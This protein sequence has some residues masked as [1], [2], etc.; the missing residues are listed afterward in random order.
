MTQ[1]SKALGV[2][3]I[4]A[5]LAQLA[6]ACGNGT[7]TPGDSSGSCGSTDIETHPIDA[8]QLAMLEQTLDCTTLCENLGSWG[9][10]ECSWTS[11]PGSGSATDDPTGGGASSGGPIPGS[12]SLADGSGTS[13][14]SGTDGSGTTS[15]MGTTDGSTS[16]HGSTTWDG[17]GTT[18]G[19]GGPGEPVATLSCSVYYECVGGRGHAA[20][21][22]AARASTAD[23][24]GEWLA[25]MAH[26][27][28]ASVVAFR[29]IAD[30]LHAHGAP[31][32]LVQR[33]R[34]AADD[35]VRHA[36]VMGTLARRRGV[37]P[38]PPRFSAIE[39]RE[40]EALARENAV[41]GCVRETWAALEACCQARRATDPALRRA[42]EGIGADESRHAQLSW[43]LDAWAR[44]KLSPA[45]IARVDAARRAAVEELERGL[46]GS[47]PA[48]LHARAGIP[49][50]AEARALLAELRR[51]LWS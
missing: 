17:F 33:A 27:E 34:E 11:P 8:A 29:A 5:L 9:T 45:A 30:E 42:M 37:E 35:E 51:A 25:A 18:T 43:D 19:D 31:A 28:A 48:P 3:A 24:L 4:A 1:T 12:T 44:T 50:P 7:I 22:P 13:D 23:A 26:S 40:L 46:S 49:E 2:S 16:E 39:P 47:R 32:E 10:T 14:G 41:E 15:G 21:Q 36:A 38:S 6:A 20:L